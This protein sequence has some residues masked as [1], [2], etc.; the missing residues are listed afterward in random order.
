MVFHVPRPV[1]SVTFSWDEQ[2]LH[3]ACRDQDANYDAKDPKTWPITL[4]WVPCPERRLPTS[5]A[6]DMVCSWGP[7]PTA[8]TTYGTEQKKC[9]NSRF[10]QYPFNFDR[11]GQRRFYGIGIPKADYGLWID[12]V[13]HYK[14]QK[15]RPM[16]NEEGVEP[17]HATG[18]ND[19]ADI[20]IPGDA[21]PVTTYDRTMSTLATLKEHRRVAEEGRRCEKI[22][23]DQLQQLNTT[24]QQQTTELATV[25]QALAQEKE[26]AHRLG[27]QLQVQITGRQNDNVT[28]QERAD[29]VGQQ[30]RSRSPAVRMTTLHRNSASKLQRFRTRVS[31]VGL[32]SCSER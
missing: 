27:Q 11:Y 20:E 13:R 17:S 7:E 10:L 9:I 24:F 32:R 1:R 29:R 3:E 22:R 8:V 31:S 14:P 25:K 5:V 23:A 28:S 21:A 19:Q 4:T 30:L 6:Y 18:T 26:R 16:P 2:Q 12:F 15:A